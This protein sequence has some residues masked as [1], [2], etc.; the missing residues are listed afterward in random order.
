MFNKCLAEDYHGRH[1]INPA[2]FLK[3]P[4]YQLILKRKVYDACVLPMA[5]YGLETMAVT[6][7][8]AHRLKVVQRSM[9]RIIYICSALHFE[10]ELE[11]KKS[12][13]EQK[14]LT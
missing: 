8:N 5:T 3:I 9:E 14:L 4:T 13:N 12:E 2:I 6:K 1:S 11:T 7:R 10:T